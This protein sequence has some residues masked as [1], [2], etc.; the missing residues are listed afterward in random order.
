M[1]E[2]VS[3]LKQGLQRKTSEQSAKKQEEQ[4]KGIEN[5]V[6]ECEL[7]EVFL[8]L[9]YLSG[10]SNKNIEDKIDHLIDQNEK[11]EHQ[12]KIARE[13]IAR[14]YALSSRV[15]G[16]NKDDAAL[17][18]R[19]KDVLNYLAFPASG[20]TIAYTYVFVE[21]KLLR[22]LN[23]PRITLAKD[24][25]PA[26][27]NHAINFRRIFTAIVGIGVLLTFVSVGLLS[28]VTYGDQVLSRFEE[29][30]AAHMKSIGEFY[31]MLAKRGTPNA[32]SPP[33]K[34]VQDYCYNEDNL[35]GATYEVAEQCN[36]YSYL[37]E[38]YNRAIDSIIEYGNSLPIRL[39][40]FIFNIP[41]LT[42]EK[43]KGTQGRVRSLAIG[44]STVTSYILPVLFAF[45]GAIAAAARGIHEKMRDCVLRPQDRILTIMRLPL[46]LMAGVAVGLF[47]D[48]STVAVRM[49][50]GLG[51]LSL[52]ASGIG[53]LAGYGAESFFSMLDKAINRIFA[54]RTAD[55]PASPKLETD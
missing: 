37:D 38:R 47:F 54:F 14:I 48:P 29:D 21:D 3:T 17:L 28:S 30:R 22:P 51:A 32:M 9:D 49:T 4:R 2:M 10:R 20:A 8:L 31:S 52:S 13:A 45:V 35:R 1:A 6:F 11:S 50:T 19:M 55:R 5:L 27:V 15:E 7:K 53:F 25:F 41:S 36:E 39:V 18:L 24:A 12:P 23:S 44:L 16:H 26:L 40:K 33:I 42:N 43:N 34:L 46:S